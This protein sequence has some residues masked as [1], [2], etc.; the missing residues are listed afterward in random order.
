MFGSDKGALATR[1]AGVKVAHSSGDE[2]GAPQKLQGVTR[3]DVIL[4][5]YT[6]ERGQVEAG[7]FFKIGE[8]YMAAPGTAEWCKSLRPVSAW[9]RKQIDESFEQEA[10]VD[11]PLKDTVD[12][13]P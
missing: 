5:Q 1:M 10:P 8:Q 3:V 9:L 2:R 7:L 6:N 12:V 11:I 13:I 4:A